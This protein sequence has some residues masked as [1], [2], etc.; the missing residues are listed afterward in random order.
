M[1]S[2]NPEFSPVRARRLMLSPVVLHDGR[3]W[4]VSKAGS[5]L[6][7]DPAF[8]SAL[9]GFSTA[10]TAA[11]QAVVDLRTRQSESPGSGDRR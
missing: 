9:N 5:M 8:T 3:W 1:S 2:P 6:A 7:T 10:A 4:L 11:D